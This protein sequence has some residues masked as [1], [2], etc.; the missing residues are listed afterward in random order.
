MKQLDLFT[1]QAGKYEFCV[2][3]Y[4]NGQNITTYVEIDKNDRRDAIF[5]GKEKLKLQYYR[6]AAAFLI[7]SPPKGSS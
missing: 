1:Q 7:S 2:T 6:Q 4:V 5:A 3:F